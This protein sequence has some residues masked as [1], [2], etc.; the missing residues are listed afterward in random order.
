MEDQS[1]ATPELTPTTPSDIQAV[2]ADV[3]QSTSET[4]VTIQAPEVVV[5]NEQPVVTPQAQ[6]QVLSHAEQL[7]YVEVVNPDGSMSQVKREVA[8][9]MVANLEALKAKLGGQQ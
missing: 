7:G 6:P 2:V 3:P 8:Q 4:T 5:P 9:K 1:Q